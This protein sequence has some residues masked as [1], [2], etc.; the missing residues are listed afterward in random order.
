MANRL[1]SRSFTKREKIM[2]LVLAV[3]LVVASYYFFVVQ[4]VA[5]TKASNTAKLEEVQDQMTVQTT[6]A[7]MRN[8]ME[9]ELGSM[10][11]VNSLPVIATYDNLRNEL[12]ELNGVLAKA[13]SY[14]LKLAQPTLEGETVRRVVTL[15]FT[16]PN[17]DTA[18]AIVE[19]LQNGKYRCEI[20]DFALTGKMLASGSVESVSGTLSITYYETTAGATNTNG[21]VE[22]KS[23]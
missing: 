13:S 5:L 8:K 7:S 20:S 11:D 22:K 14:D 4:N 15:T 6:I 3:L 1:M 16:T 23:S 10:G 17:Y 19:G 21:L 2:I 12:D 18:M 9:Q